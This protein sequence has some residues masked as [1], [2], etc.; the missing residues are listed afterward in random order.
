MLA[1]TGAHEKKFHIIREIQIKI[2][3]IKQ[4]TPTTMAFKTLTLQSPNEDA[5]QLKHSYIAAGNVKCY[6]HFAKWFSSL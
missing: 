2:T 6:S 3:K 1:T 4:Y 5:E